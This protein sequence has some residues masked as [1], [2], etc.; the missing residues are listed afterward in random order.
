MKFL[1]LYCIGS[2]ICFVSIL[3]ELTFNKHYLDVMYD[4]HKEMKYSSIILGSLLCSFIPVLN[5]I[6]LIFNSIDVFM[7]NIS[8]NYKYEVWIKKGD[9]DE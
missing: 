7:Y 5:I 8:E 4:I 3:A 2:L 6:L 1:I 9:K